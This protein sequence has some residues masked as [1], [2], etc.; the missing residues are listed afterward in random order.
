MTHIDALLIDHVGIAVQ[1]LDDTIAAYRDQYALTLESRHIVAAQGVE[2]AML[3]I[4]DGYV[5]LVSPLADDTTVARFLQRRGEGLHHLAYR[6]AA[7]E[8]ALEHLAAAGARLLDTTPRPGAAGTRIAFV[9]PGALAG[10]LIELV[11]RPGPR[12]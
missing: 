4:G 6:V 10:T 8:P 1:D 9:H 2:E 5:Q 3:R 7:I 12:A 11:E